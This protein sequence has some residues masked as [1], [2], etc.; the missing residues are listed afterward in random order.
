MVKAIWKGLGLPGP[1]QRL[2]RICPQHSLCTG[3]PV[4][5]AWLPTRHPQPSRLHPMLHCS[6]HCSQFLENRAISR[7]IPMSSGS[8]AQSLRQLQLW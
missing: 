4:C 1:P 7:A 2:N 6:F 5:P 8:S 3:P